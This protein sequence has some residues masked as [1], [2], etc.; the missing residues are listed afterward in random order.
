MKKEKSRN[1]WATMLFLCYC[2]LMCYLLFVQGRVAD[3]GLP[4]WD[5]VQK[6]YNL[7][8]W[9]TV[10][11]YWDV[12]S[13]PEFYIQK[14]GSESAYRYNALVALI[15]I[16]GNIIMFVPFGMFLP[17]MWTK[18]QRAWKAIPVG[19]LIIVLIEICQ[20]LTLRGRCDV[21]DILLNV[22]G[23]ILGYGLWRFTVFCTRKGKYL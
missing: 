16:S 12:L 9:K 13:R 22:P 4:Y 7:T 10:G 8:I 6:N 11:N 23:I 2:A 1:P 20:L 19:L 21:D 15:N 3:D 5:Q 17:A 14:W 18:L